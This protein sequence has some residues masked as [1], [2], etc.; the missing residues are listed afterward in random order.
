MP[1]DNG[2][3]TDDPAVLR[4]GMTLIHQKFMKTLEGQG[5]SKSRHR[6]PTSTPTFTKP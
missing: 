1:I 2:E 5:V 3:K 4:E 6:M